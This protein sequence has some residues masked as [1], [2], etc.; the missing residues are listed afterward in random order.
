MVHDEIVKSNRVFLLGFP[1]EF[2]GGL[3][4]LEFLVPLLFELAAVEEGVPKE[5]DVGLEHVGVPAL[6]EGLVDLA[7]VPLE[8]FLV[9]FLDVAGHQRPEDAGYFG[10]FLFIIFEVELKGAEGDAAVVEG[11]NF[12][13][14][15]VGG[16]RGLLDWGEKC[17]NITH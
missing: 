17:F 3:V 13:A 8:R 1:S 15:A 11:G 9:E 6:L 12:E 4:L 5:A 14:G 16:S 2:E 7:H 10:D